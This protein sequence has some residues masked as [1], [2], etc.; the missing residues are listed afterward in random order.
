MN[1]E[2]P[3]TIFFQSPLT[4]SFIVLHVHKNPSNI[5]ENIFSHMKQLYTS[6]MKVQHQVFLPLHYVKENG[7][8]HVLVS[9]LASAALK[10][11]PQTLTMQ[12]TYWWCTW[13]LSSLFL[14]N[15]K[16]QH[17]CNVP[18]RTA[19]D[20]NNEITIT[21]KPQIFKSTMCMIVF[22]LFLIL[23]LI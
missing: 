2:P 4:S 14:V 15:A 23:F 11:G 9:H 22:F 19:N 8:L 10:A 16:R 6:K 1:S 13:H 7:P 12:H 18:A 21:L 5:I 17:S 3:H 20:T